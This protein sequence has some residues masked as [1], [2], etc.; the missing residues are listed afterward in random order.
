M[1]VKKV[2][3]PWIG[4]G[5][6]ALAASNRQTKAASSSWYSDR[7]GVGVNTTSPMG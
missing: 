6:D 5:V 1:Q 4:S 2:R 3:W 7:T